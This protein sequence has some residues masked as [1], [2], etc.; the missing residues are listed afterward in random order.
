M[1]Q[2]DYSPALY[3]HERK[4]RRF[5]LQFPVSIRFPAGQEVRELDAVT[6]NVSLG[7]LLLTSSDEVP[8]RTQVSLTMN[9]K[10]PLARRAVRLR[11]EGRVVRVE[12]LGAGA[13]FA[14]AVECTQSI[15]EMEEYFPAAG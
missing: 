11:G 9:V 12:M 8:P 13:G 4:H 2:S 7:G 6:Q 10:S 14:I 3:L 1:L 15:T 5:D